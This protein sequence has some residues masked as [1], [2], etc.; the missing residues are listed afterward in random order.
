MATLD[1]IIQNNKGYR[2]S[3]IT[4]L[5]VAIIAVCKN[6]YVLSSSKFLLSV[7]LAVVAVTDQRCLLSS[8]EWPGI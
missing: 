2:I 8:S 5:L 7:L 1:T 4:V 6:E 3:V